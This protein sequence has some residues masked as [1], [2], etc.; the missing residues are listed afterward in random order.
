MS[1][2]RFS[3]E[4]LAEFKAAQRLAYDATAAVE[5]QLYEGITERQAARALE[6]WLRGNGV[7]RFFHY[8]F[9]WFGDRTRFRGFDRPSTN[10]LKDLF[11]PKMAHF[12]AQF[13]PTDRRLAR[14]DA[15]ILDVGPIFGRAA[16]DM[17]YSCTLGEEITPEFHEARMALAPYRS[18]VLDLVRHGETQ[19]RIYREID[20]LIADQGYENIHSYYPGSV[21][22]HRVGRVRGLQLPTFRVKGFSPQALAYLTGHI[23]ES[24]VRPARH[25]TPIWNEGSDRPCEPGLWAVE[26]HIGKGD[27]GVKFE[28]LLVVTDDS[29][30]WLDDDLPHVRYWQAHQ[31]VG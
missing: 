20:G 5:A 27:I 6:D 30:Y 14:G 11:S 16:S 2:E 17:G 7:E 26:P 12:G 8:G 19:S 28:E 21:I 18:T 13:L 1:R 23:I 15:V 22:A 31:T 3:A 10:P 4:E 29:A 9:A 25:Q 24:A